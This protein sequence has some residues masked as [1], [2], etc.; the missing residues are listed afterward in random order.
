MLLLFMHQLRRQ[1]KSLVGS[2]FTVYYIY[3]QYIYYINLPFGD[4]NFLKTSLFSNLIKYCI[5]R[6]KYGVDE[7]CR[8]QWKWASQNPWGYRSK[9]E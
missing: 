5:F 6:A 2:K 1:R 7:M 4:S 8:D 9:P 3:L